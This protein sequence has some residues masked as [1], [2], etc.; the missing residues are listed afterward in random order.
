M[1]K[2]TGRIRNTHNYWV[3]ATKFAK[4]LV[5]EDIE[6]RFIDYCKRKKYNRNEMLFFRKMLAEAIE[7]NFMMAMLKND[8]DEAEPKEKKQKENELES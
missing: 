4:T 3:N 7:F 6:K 8:C 2:Q 5:P 1:T